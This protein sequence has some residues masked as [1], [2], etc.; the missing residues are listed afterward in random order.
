MAARLRD[1]GLLGDHQG[2]FLLGKDRT[3][4]SKHAWPQLHASVVDAG[5]HSHRATIGVNQGVDGH[6]HGRKFPTGQRINLQLGT[7]TGFDL[8]LK[9]L[10]QTVIHVDRIHVLEVDDVGAIFEVITQVDG[11]DTDRAV[12]RGQNFQPGRRCLS[13]SQLGLRHLKVGRTLIDRTAADEVLLHQLFVAVE[14]RSRDRQFSLRLLDLGLRQ[15][16]VELHQQ[17]PPA[18]TLAVPKIDLRDATADLRPDDDA[19]TRAQTAHR[20]GLVDQPGLLDLSHLHSRFATSSWRPPRAARS[21]RASGRGRGARR[22]RRRG[23]RRCVTGCGLDRTI[24]IP[25]GTTAHCSNQ[26]HGQDPDHGFGRHLFASEQKISP[27]KNAGKRP[28]SD[29]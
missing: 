7:L 13:Q 5:T 15:L 18:H 22:A 11:P 6:H 20:L 10:W 26:D 21:G 12:K 1:D 3:H 9:T 19:L 29:H 14:V 16:I 28:H 24:L 25:P 2:L 27:L 17:L 4:P 8:G 23:R